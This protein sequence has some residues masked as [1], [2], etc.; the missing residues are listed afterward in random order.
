MDGLKRRIARYWGLRMEKFSALRQKEF[1]DKKRSLWLA[2]LKRA[3][4]QGKSLDVLDAGT[5]TGFFAF[6]L[7]A[8][9]HR[10]TGIDL[11]PEMIDEAKRLAECLGLKIKF[12][13]M[14]AEKPDLPPASFDAVVTRN[15]T[16]AL[17]H[18]GDAYKNWR[19][20]L[21]PGGVLINFDADYCREEKPA[22]LPE[23]HAHR[24]IEPELMEEYERL[25]DELR[26]SQ[27]PRPE[28]DVKLLEA[29]G[30]GGVGVDLS[31]WRRIYEKTDEFYNP[32]PI[33]MITARA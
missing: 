19:A 12:C 11:T 22:N 20:L 18:L 17:P 4:P 27:M 24:G 26:P 5:G 6:L 7:A 23:N 16:W 25:K 29:A 14:D 8:E 9:G 15:L 28:W 10:V 13:V 32:T 1:E 21:R 2:E 31:V 3:L 30:F 33:F